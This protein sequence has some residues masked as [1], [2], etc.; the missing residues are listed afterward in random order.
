MEQL[1]NVKFEQVFT[2]PL[3][4]CTKLA[5]YCGFPNA[6]RDNRLKEMHFGDWESTMIYENESEEVKAWFKDQLNIRAPRGESFNDLM[7]RFNAFIAEQKAA[8]YQSILIFSHGG[9]VLSAQLLTGKTFSGDLF[10]HLPP[11]GSLTSFTF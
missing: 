9:I 2:S 4:R 1:K 3:S 5:D 6:I 10:A 8:N 7:E 11:Y